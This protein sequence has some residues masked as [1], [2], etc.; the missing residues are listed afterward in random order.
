MS[1]TLSVFKATG[2]ADGPDDGGEML[3][4]ALTP[5]QKR[6]WRSDR[7]LPGNRSLNGAFLLEITG[8][9]RPERVAAAF[10]LL[11]ERHEILRAT[12]QLVD[13][14]P[15]LVVAPAMAPRLAVTDL[16]YLTA[17]AADLAMNDICIGEARLSFD[18]EKGPLI[19][20]GLIQLPNERAILM[21]TVHQL[22]ADGWSVSRL[23]EEFA[24]DYQALSDNRRPD[25]PELAIQFGDYASW[26]DEQSG[27]AQFANQVEFWRHALDGYS[28]LDIAPDRRPEPGSERDS[29][30]IGRELPAALTERLGAAAAAHS[31]TMFSTALS[32]CMAV[33]RA[34]SCRDDIALAT[35]V[36]G[37]E[38]AELEPLIGPLLN[39]VLLRVKIDGDPTFGELQAK[40]RA[41][42]IE[43]M[44]NQSVP[45]ETVAEALATS[46]TPLPDPAYS[47]V[48]VC[49]RGLGGAAHFTHEFDGCR[50]RTLPSKSQGALHDLF[51]FMVERETGWRLSVEYRTALFSQGRAEALLERLVATL[52]RIAATPDA[53]LSVLIA[54]APPVGEALADVAG[55]ETFVLPASL[56]QQRFWMLNKATQNGAAFNMP[57]FVKIVGP[58]SAE[59]LAQSLE[60]LVARH[61]ILRTTFEQI[62]NELCQVVHPAIACPMSVSDL[63]AIEPDQRAAECE[64]L[65]R[66]EAAAP[67][68]LAAGPLIRARLIKLA[69]DDA[70]LAL[71]LHHI[72]SD[73]QS[74]GILQNELWAAYQALVAGG[75]P[76]LPQLAIQYGD[77]A[78][79]Q[80]AWL[81]TPAAE[82][83]V[84]YWKR[85][86]A[87]PLPV[88]DFPL[89]SLPTFKPQSRAA[90]ELLELDAQLLAA[91]KQLGQT[92]GATMFM[93][94]SAAFAALL[95]RYAQ[96]TDIL[97]GC[98]IA[99]RSAETSGI[100]GPFAGPLALRYNLGGDP[101]LRGI[102]A[103][104]RD[105]ALDALS[106][107]DVPFDQLVTHLDARSVHGRNPLFQFYFLY[108]SAFLQARTIGELR[109][110]PV[111]TQPTGTP[112]EL[113]LALIER[114]G[115]VT[116]QLEYNPDLLEADSAKTILGYYAEILSRLANSP[117]TLLSSLLAP[118]VSAT[119]KRM[120]NVSVAAVYAAPRT[121]TE[122][123]LVAI[124]ESLLGRS[125]IGI[126]D[127][128][129]DLGGQSILAARLVVAIE[130]E[131]GVRTQISNVAF[132]RNIQ[133]MADVLDK[134]EGEVAPR[135][136]PMRETGNKLPIF[137]IHCG[138]GHVLRYQDLVSIMP[139]DQ[140]IFGLAAPP[141]DGVK[142]SLSVE[143]LA[144]L[145]V[146]E[147]RRVQPHGPYQIAGYSFG[148]IVAYEM[149]RQ[150]A[151]AGEF[152]AMVAI[153]DTV[154]R[155]HY[156][157]QS[158][159]SRMRMRA[160]R[161]MDLTGRYSR[162]LRAKRFD[163]VV[164]DASQA[165][166]R[167]LK[168]VGWRLART[169]FKLA[170]RPMPEGLQ[171]N[172]A[173]FA[174]LADRYK[175]GPYNGRVLIVYAEE[176]GLEY[177]A[178]ATLGW[179][180]VA[181][182]G[183]E[184][185]YVP[186]NHMTFM[187]KPNVDAVAGH[188]IDFQQ[189]S[190]HRR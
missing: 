103:M 145:Y 75:E 176:R 23:L 7:A 148:G 120:A 55:D 101:T 83:Q 29:A 84:A 22:I 104:A 50:M 152:I 27:G 133:R 24:T 78:A 124:W 185:R 42:S 48:F 121:A 134:P 129:F 52:E 39:H 53:R 91:L 94:T 62:D 59:H 41:A 33:L 142:E 166:G 178:N 190:T 96:S 180:D 40:V 110:S 168:P 20:T 60:H 80:R 61:E 170:D 173:L 108:Q 116:A 147:I 113:Q 68:D 81:D 82:A 179:E 154:N 69:A 71:T 87:A 67:F 5:Q 161:I 114:A 79:A 10:S 64:A 19:R 51:F 14:R 26:L 90:I 183:V 156:R 3:V 137:L 37:R 128:F 57:A 11:A 99:N 63:S 119:G 140:P 163:R 77:V 149:A 143:Q 132:A 76:G 165:I 144:E 187:H 44:A 85:T 151:L 130:R 139:A 43:A 98:P 2:P 155:E 16:R 73:G 30:I 157:Q 17:D 54:N 72:I 95:A 158:L 21:L 164:V 135:L 186:G 9:L 36:A 188:L 136:I 97:F 4:F 109:I 118:P 105:R 184:V 112:Y 150:L 181:L 8:P 167:R 131:M 171:D 141:L 12:A 47:V 123:K 175:P 31:C 126:H 189:N 160:T 146:N 88:A 93:V 49:Q 58:L 106:N 122:R 153:L 92:E 111:P 86:L 38:R 125:P 35:P 32:A 172:L 34:D 138:G 66:A 56:G 169:V 74:I 65:L 15:Q 1:A 13:G 115:K 182:D 6:I 117:E 25:L 46:S 177:R 159:A 18:L 28:R 45:L 127:D 107:A 174:D 162:K 89:D 102:V 100:I 70:R